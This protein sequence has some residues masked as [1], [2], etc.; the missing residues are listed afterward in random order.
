MGRFRRFCRSL[1]GKSKKQP[2]KPKRDDPQV[3]SE[4][5]NTQKKPAVDQGAPAVS[6]KSSPVP[7]QSPTHPPATTP[8]QLPTTPRESSQSAILTAVLRPMHSPPAETGPPLQPSA[9]ASLPPPQLPPTPQDSP[10]LDGT[11]L[12]ASLTP[13]SLIKPLVA[14]RQMADI[15]TSTP[16]EGQKQQLREAVQYIRPQPRI[17]VP[18]LEAKDWAHN[19]SRPGRSVQG[20]KG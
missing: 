3:S 2:P 12:P 6:T 16:K 14:V 9:R 8:K 19:Q 15:S 11:E 10:N 4:T 5:S 18:V 13:G 7:P 1:K 20:D 17:P